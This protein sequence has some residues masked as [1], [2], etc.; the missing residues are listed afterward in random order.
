MKI[1]GIIPAR[2]GSTRL[3]GK[4]Y[5]LFDGKPL[6]YYTLSTCS[7]VKS[8]DKFVV[9][10][11]SIKVIECAKFFNNIEILERPSELCTATSKAIDY[12]KH[13]LNYFRN[14]LFDTIAIIQ[15]TSPLT[16]VSDIEGVIKSF[17][18]EKPDTAVTVTKLN[19]MYF[20]SKIKYI[21]NNRLFSYFEEENNITDK[22]SLPN[23]Y[24]RNGSVY[25]T[26]REIIDQ[27]KIIGNNCIG[28]IM[29]NERSIDINELVDFEFAEYLYKKNKKKN[30]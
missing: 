19:F 26:R 9:S 14:E 24:V 5:K 22:T 2:E 11:N 15:P 8:I 3:E 27:G 28:Y 13:A 4:N 1:L 7:K 18:K 10:T 30:K 17:K 21:K 25:V 12:V 29:P 6:V 23:L 16:V 20:P